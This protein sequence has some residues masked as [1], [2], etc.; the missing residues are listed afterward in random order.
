MKYLAVFLISSCLLLSSCAFVALGFGVALSATGNPNRPPMAYNDFPYQKTSQEYADK[1]TDQLESN[2]KVIRTWFHYTVELVDES[3]ILK[4]YYPETKQLTDYYTYS[5]HMLF[6][7]E[8]VCKEWWDNGNKKLEGS[9][10]DNKH[11]GEWTFYDNDGLVTKTG[12]F[13]KGL[14]EGKWTFNRKKEVRLGVFNYSNDLRNGPFELFNSAKKSIAKGTFFQGKLES[15]DWDTEDSTQYQ[16]FL[17]SPMIDQMQTD[18]TAATEECNDFDFEDRRRECTKEALT[19]ITADNFEY[20]SF[21]F[22]KGVEGTAFVSFTIDAEGQLS[23]IK[24][25]RGLTKSSS[26]ECQ[27][28]AEMLP[29]TWIPAKK[30]GKNVAIDYVLP[31]K[32]KIQKEIEHNTEE[33]QN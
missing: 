3:Y 28:V 6:M 29:K 33:S 1:Y 22:E 16:R 10:K 12:F 11:T 31:I 15:V 21:D 7:K 23:D 26:E 4:K 18:Q 13:R 25:L 19:K 24:V 5:N 2:T 27:R 30:N 17:T 20:P 32:L 9:F 8:G 14:R